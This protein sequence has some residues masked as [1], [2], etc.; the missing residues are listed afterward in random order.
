MIIPNAVRRTLASRLISVVF[1]SCAASSSMTSPK[2][3]SSIYDFSVKDIDSNDVSMERYKGRVLIIVNVATECGYTNRNYEQLQQLYDR[4]QSKGLSIAAFPCNQFGHQ[5]RLQ[6]PKCELDIKKFATE[7]YKVTFDM[8]SK[9]DVNGKNA[10]PLWVY[11]REKQSG[12]LGS[13]IKWN[14]TKFLVDRAGQPVKRFGPNEDPEE[15]KPEAE[16]KKFA[17]EKYNVTFDMYAKIDVNGNDAHPLWVYLKAKQGGTL[18]SFIKWNFTKFL[19]DRTGQPVKRFGPKEAPEVTEETVK[20]IFSPYGAIYEVRLPMKDGRAA[21]FAFVQYINFPDAVKALKNMNAK[22]VQN[23]TVA[24]DWAVPKETYVAAQIEE[25]CK[26]EN[27]QVESRV[28]KKLESSGALGQP[29]VESSSFKSEDRAQE[30]KDAEDPTEPAKKRSKLSEKPTK[31]VADKGISDGRTLFIRQEEI[32]IAFRFLQRFRNLSFEVTDQQL[33]EFFANYGPVKY[34]LVCRYKGTNHSKGTAFVQF[35]EKASVDK[36]FQ[37]AANGL[38]TMGSSTVSLCRAVTREDLNKIKLQRAQ[39]TA[40]KPKDVRNLHLLSHSVIEK[41]SPHAE[42]MS[43]ADKRRRERIELANQ[44][45]LRNLNIFVST[46]RLVIHNLPLTLMDS[47]LKSICYKAVK[48]DTAR[49]KECRIM[50]DL[51]RVNSDN[52]GRSLGYGFVEFTEHEHAL[53]CLKALNNNP[54]I[55]TDE[56]RPIVEFSLENK[57]VLDM[58][59]QRQERAQARQKAALANRTDELTERNRKLIPKNDRSSEA[60]KRAEKRKE[61]R[62]FFTN[63]ADWFAHKKRQKINKKLQKGRLRKSHFKKA[64]N[65]LPTAKPV[66]AK[67]TAEESVKSRKTPNQVHRWYND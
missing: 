11:L 57:L 20:K 58:K 41:E 7:T 54:D 45:K 43:A 17:T 36:C 14:F 8:Y 9:I 32:G 51:N 49:I 13:F 25:K 67:S 12:T 38:L 24:I 2:E 59:K 19:I 46:C 29:F 56:K 31:N 6:E 47:Q 35:S 44:A 61:R 15:P 23:R 34:A 28:L 60:A 18:G 50:R 4:Y 27:S 39:E 10:H 48:N 40:K 30:S 52:I 37:A 21:G 64:D 53:C 55:F 33:K 5:A 42:T 3:A 1:A 63:R 62:L 66:N 22:L 26:S 65:N 16:I